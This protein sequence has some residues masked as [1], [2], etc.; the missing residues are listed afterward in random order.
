MS[1]KEEG[2]EN[3]S[4]GNDWEV[5]SLT[6]SAYAASPGPKGMELKDD[7][8][9]ATHYEAETSYPLF[10]SRHFTF[11]LSEH[12]NL[13]LEQSEAETREDKLSKKIDFG[14]GLEEDAMTQVKEEGD[15]T[16]KGLNLSNE[17]SGLQ[18]IGDKGKKEES[19]IYNAAISSL[20]DE[21]T[22]G[23]SNVYEE[24]EPIPDISPTIG[25]AKDDKHEERNIPCEAWWR[26]SAASLYAHAKEANSFWSIFIAA[27]V[28]GLIVL[29]QQWRQERWQVLQIKW[30][31][32]IGK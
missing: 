27:T 21:R 4:H 32:S 12:E 1:D 20:D 30:Q 24:K 13:P 10:M 18:F 14:F 23:G 25:A 29:G 6:A 22:I 26:R 28:M 11:P 8:K 5:V 16:L 9:G 2:E 15:L 3:T 19:I 17:F 31:S 7:D